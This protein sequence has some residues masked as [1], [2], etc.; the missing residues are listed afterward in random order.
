MT[1]HNTSDPLAY[2][3]LSLY[4][5][6]GHLPISLPNLHACAHLY[7]SDANSLFIISNA[8][9]FGDQVGKM[10]SLSHS[11]VFHVPTSELLFQGHDEEGGKL[12]WWVQ[13]AWTPTSGQGRGMHESQ[14]WSPSGRHVASTW[15][16]GL[17]RRA[18][19]EEGEKQRLMWE[20]G[21]KKNGRLRG[22]GK[23]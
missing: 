16:E 23:L 10:G 3:T 12:E 7:A 9:G 4:R 15:Q 8:L 14:I 17:I 6:F 19:R 20:E 11:V 21:M 22:R 2:R 18:E 13:E 5:P 1:H